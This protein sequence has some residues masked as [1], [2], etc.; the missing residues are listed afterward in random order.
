MPIRI[1]WNLRLL[2]GVLLFA[3]G[4]AALLALARNGSENFWV[5][6]AQSALFMVWVIGLAA[7]LLFLLKAVFDQ[8]NGALLAFLIFMFIQLGVVTVSVATTYFQHSLSAGL[9]APLV[10]D[11]SFLVRNLAI[12]CIAS[13]ALI[14]YGSFYYQWRKQVEAE[15]QA[16]LQGLQAR[17]HPHFLFNV[18]NTIASLVASAPDK[19]ERAILDLSD[20]LRTGLKPEGTHRLGDELEMIR[21]YLRIE[22]LRL[23]ARLKV[24]WD[25]ADGLPSEEKIP[26]LLIQPL[27]ENAIVHGI[28]RLPEGGTLSIRADRPRRKRLRFVIENTVPEDE[29]PAPGNRTALDNIRQR[30]ELAYEEG[31]RLRT[32]REDG[33]FVVELVLPID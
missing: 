27:V 9:I 2:L 14:A 31:A 22:A 12:S 30:L 28:A 5:A 17:I 19:A 29:S 25:L 8:I 26:R 13:F 10:E 4:L 6:L 32:R 11:G 16:R 33:R 18:L 20:L 21:G 15:Y 24:S 3:L 7:F 1:L 23:G